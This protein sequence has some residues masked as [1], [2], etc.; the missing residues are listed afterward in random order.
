MLQ[1][2]ASILAIVV[3][4]SG[5]VGCAFGVAVTV[6]VT[7]AESCPPQEHKETFKRHAEM[8]NTGINKEF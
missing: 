6:N 4:V 8:E 3:V 5:V 2:K 7:N 1:I